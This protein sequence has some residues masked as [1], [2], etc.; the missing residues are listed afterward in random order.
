MHYIAGYEEIWRTKQATKKVLVTP[1]SKDQKGVYA[2]E[3]SL[4]GVCVA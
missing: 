2:C 4:L 3:N 1:V